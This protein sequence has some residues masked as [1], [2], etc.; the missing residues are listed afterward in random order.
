MEPIV[1]AWHIQCRLNHYLLAAIAPEAMSTPLAKG[2]SVVANF[3][4]IHNVRLMWLKVCAPD[5]HAGQTK[6]EDANADHE[7]LAQRLSESDEAIAEV[8]K[9]AESP[10]GKV[11]GFKPHAAAYFGY[12]TAHEA[13]HRAAAEFALRQA[14]TPL[15][16]KVSYGL[17]EWGVR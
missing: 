11:K 14:G 16:D 7:T 8:F 6:F 9:R 3:T 4:H 2:K 17:W 1:E 5:L 10:D 13:Y 12:L 15:S